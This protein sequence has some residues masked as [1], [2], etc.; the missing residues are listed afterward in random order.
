MRRWYKVK[1][2][3][4]GTAVV[5]TCDLLVLGAYYGTGAKGGL[6]GARLHH[7]FFC[8]VRVSIIGLRLG[9]C[10]VC[11]LR[12]RFTHSRMLVEFHAFAPLEALAFV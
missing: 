1:G 9:C 2:D 11:V 10:A 5:D 7:G 8:R 6:Y 3:H 4:L 12:Q